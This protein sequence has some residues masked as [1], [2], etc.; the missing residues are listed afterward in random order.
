MELRFYVDGVLGDTVPYTTGVN[1]TRTQKLF[2]IGAEWNGALQYVGSVDRLKVSS[3]MLTPEQLDFQKVPPAGAAALVIG[4]P[5]VTPFNFSVGVT[6]VGGSVADPDT[7]ALTFDGA[8]VTPTAVT[9]RGATTT[10]SYDVP[11]PPL[12]SGSSHTASLTIKDTRGGGLHR[13]RQFC[14]RHLRDLAHRRRT[15]RPVPWTRPRRASR[16]R[17]TRLMAAPRTAPS[18]TTRT[19]SRA[20]SDRTWPGWT[21]RAAWTATGTSRGPT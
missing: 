20:A 21:T 12:P 4:R 14:R 5:S 7:I 17:P 13:K 11:N 2:S 10:I 15:C 19:C 6:E 9:K 16:S 8:A 1:F 3:G 18:P